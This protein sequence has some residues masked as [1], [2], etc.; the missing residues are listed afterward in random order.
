MVLMRGNRIVMCG[1]T[2]SV[3]GELR[4]CLPQILRQ[5]LH[6]FHWQQICRACEDLQIHCA[7]CSSAQ[8]L[9]L[10]T[11]GVLPAA[12]HQCGL[13]TKSD[14]ERLTRWVLEEG[15]VDFFFG[16][17]TREHFE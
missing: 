1:S 10:K 16:G 6:A 14:A 7:P 2:C 5:T 4:L 12:A 11:A 3:G 15:I 9:A 8:L 13:I 17:G